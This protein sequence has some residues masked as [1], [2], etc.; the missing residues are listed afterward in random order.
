MVRRLAGHV[1]ALEV[2]LQGVPHLLGGRAVLDLD[3]E[4]VGDV[5]ADEGDR[6]GVVARLQ[7]GREDHAG[8]GL[9]GRPQVLGL[10]REAHGGLP[11][12]VVDLGQLV[13]AP[14]GADG[15]GRDDALKQ[16]SVL[17]K[18]CL[19]ADSSGFVG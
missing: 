11:V 3:V 14:D 13:Y 17:P 8:R 5:E 18:T 10:Q 1:L 15:A 4:V 7:V 19:K 2:R 16:C 6:Q 9:D 12:G